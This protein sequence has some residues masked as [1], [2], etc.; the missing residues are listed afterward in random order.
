MRRTRHGL[1]SGLVLTVVVL[2]VRAPA[3][4]AA[5][6][7]QLTIA[8]F[9]PS[10]EF[11]T[12]ARLSYLNQVA[13][14]IEAKTGI[15]TIARSFV[16]YSD[17][18]G[19]KPDFAIVEAQCIAARG[20]GTALATATIN[21]ARTTDWGLYSRA[22]GQTLLELRAK[23]VAYVKT[24]CRDSDFLDHAL[25]LGVFRHDS[26]F[27]ATVAKADAPGA[28]VG[29]RDSGDADAVVAPSRLATGLSLVVVI[30][31]VPNP[32]LV[33]MNDKLDATLIA[34]ARAAVVGTSGGPI[35]GWADAAGYDS[36]AGRM[37]G[38]K[39]PLVLAE[40]KPVEVSEPAA[41]RA[42]IA[43]VHTVATHLLWQPPMKR[44]RP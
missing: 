35:G 8:I 33:V 2:V 7:E 43:A 30:D 22:K 34:A 15:P 9:A 29:T 28:V 16:K 19:A 36:L 26:F 21:G 31:A 14:A 12:T 39:K 1:A 11:T 24:G 32:G 3:G 37:A 42:P 40:P 41:I 23:K 20:P 18:A 17:L 6:P 13:D 4:H 5:P 38:R 25:L 27:S 10:L 44:A